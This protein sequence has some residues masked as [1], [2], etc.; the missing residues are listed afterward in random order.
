[1]NDLLTNPNPIELNYDLTHTHRLVDDQIE[2]ASG[3]K[4]AD[5][6]NQIADMRQQICTQA[7]NIG[8]YQTREGQQAAHIVNMERTIN[9][10]TD[11]VV[12]Y[13]SAMEQAQSLLTYFESN[14]LDV[15]GSNQDEYDELNDE[16]KYINQL[17]AEKCEQAF[18]LRLANA[19]LEKRVFWWRAF[20]AL[21]LLAAWGFKLVGGAS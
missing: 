5:L 6:Q 10:L 16:Y 14:M 4:I 9:R 1:M 7:E 15:L 13:Q 17:W 20:T 2:S 11:D 18:Q 19:E 8:V 21:A 12:F 3:R